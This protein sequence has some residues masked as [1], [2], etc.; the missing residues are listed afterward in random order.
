M[1]EISRTHSFEERFPFRC[2]FSFIS[3]FFF[4]CHFVSHI[5]DCMALITLALAA[6]D[7]GARLR[8]TTTI[9]TTKSDGGVTIKSV[10]K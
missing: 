3:F 7:S 6:V 9:T 1:V 4:L 8:T 10:K 2:L 5:V